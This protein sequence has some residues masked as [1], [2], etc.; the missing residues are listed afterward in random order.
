MEPEWLLNCVAFCYEE[1]NQP[2]YIEK[3]QY[4]LQNVEK[5]TIV[6]LDQIVLR[7]KEK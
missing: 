5:Y 6:K 2:R 3:K 7:A 4:F 1:E